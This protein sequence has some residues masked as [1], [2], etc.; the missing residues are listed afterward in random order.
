MARKKPVNAFGLALLVFSLVVIAITVV[1]VTR[2]SP[3]ITESAAACRL[4]ARTCINNDV[5]KCYRP[6]R[7]YLYDDCGGDG[8]CVSG[9]CA[10]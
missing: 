1:V 9:I 2:K 5:Y 8:H 6:G 7:W 10:D 4:G 3:L